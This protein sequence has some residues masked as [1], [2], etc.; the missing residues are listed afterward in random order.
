MEKKYFFLIL[1]LAS[2]LLLSILMHTLIPEKLTLEEITKEKL[3]QKIQT[4]AKIIKI[5]DFP[6][7]SFQILTL[8]DK[9]S[10]IEATS[11]SNKQLEL[12]QNQTYL[13]TGKIQEYNH[14]I[15]LA[16]DKIE[17]AK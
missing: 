16:I 7:S 1:S 11:N 8:K 4:E 13:I 15:Q 17:I 6:E 2:I 3:N 14:T 12:K 9:T 10:S 5:K